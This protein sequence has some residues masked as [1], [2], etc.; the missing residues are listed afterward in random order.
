MVIPGVTTG[1]QGLRAQA[2]LL[3]PHAV[4]AADQRRYRHRGR[5]QLQV[6]LLIVL[7]VSCIQLQLVTTVRISVFVVGDV[8]RVTCARRDREMLL[9]G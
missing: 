1:L 7:V 3:R 4:R 2:V 8:E 9:L 5:R 6:G